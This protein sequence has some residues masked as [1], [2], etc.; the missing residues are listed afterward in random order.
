LWL[1]IGELYYFQ[2][3]LPPGNNRKQL[4]ALLSLVYHLQQQY[5]D[6]DVDVV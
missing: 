1:Y 5:V 3:V 4:I 2:L 6:V